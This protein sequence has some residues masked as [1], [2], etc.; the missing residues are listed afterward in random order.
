[1]GIKCPSEGESRKRL[2]EREMET[3]S[4]FKRHMTRWHGGYTEEQIQAAISQ[5]EPSGET[6]A[7]FA[8]VSSE[9]P[10]RVE[11]EAGTREETQRQRTDVSRKPR[12]SSQSKALNQKLNECIDLT[13]KHLMGTI[14]EEEKDELNTKRGELVM[15]SFG[16]QFN[17]DDKIVAFESKWMLIL[18][19][20][21]LYLVP[22]LPTAKTM[23][24]MY[25]EK[26][27]KEAE[28]KEAVN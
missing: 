26:Q 1:M 3:L 5:L 20:I 7:E 6:Q 27:K 8:D 23:M 4:G 19:L 15:A 2:C 16:A 17:F 24:S 21:A 22:N 11:G 28:K 12:Q 18:M 14:K 10:A 9:F 13:V 25:K